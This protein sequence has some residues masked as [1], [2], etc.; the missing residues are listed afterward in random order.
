MKKMKWYSRIFWALVLTALV[1]GVVK[2][3]WVFM[4]MTQGKYAWVAIL[5]AVFMTFFGAIGDEK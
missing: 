3:V 5:V 2:G 1:F 4:E